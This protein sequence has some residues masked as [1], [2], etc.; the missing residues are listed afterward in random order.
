[1]KYSPYQ[2]HS[3]Q[4]YKTRLGTCC[5]A[6]MSHSHSHPSLEYFLPFNQSCMHV[7]MYVYMF[8]AS[9][10]WWPLHAPRPHHSRQDEKILFLPENRRTNSCSTNLVCSVRA[11]R[12][13]GH[14]T[15][16]TLA[17]LY[18]APYSLKVPPTPPF[19]IWPLSYWKNK[20]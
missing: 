16:P 20:I 6:V 10:A 15:H 5:Y 17:T 11:R 12:P 3:E 14:F 1:M 13:G 4:D 7:Y 19:S 9:K 18:A 2:H 8:H